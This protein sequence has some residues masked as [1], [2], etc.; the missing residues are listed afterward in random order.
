MNI[1]INAN[2][3]GGLAL[4]KWKSV[5]NI[6]QH[7]GISYQVHLTNSL[8]EL[9]IILRKIIPSPMSEKL[10]LVS[11]GGDGAINALI[12]ESFN[13][14]SEEERSFLHF[15]AINLGSSNDFH[16]PMELTQNFS[17]KISPDSL[18]QDLG[19]CEMSTINSHSKRFFVINSGIGLT[20][21]GN[22]FF[23]TNPIV[24]KLKPVSFALANLYTLFNII[25][26]PFLQHFDISLID[27]KNIKLT[28]SQFFSNIGVLKNTHVSGSMKFDTLVTKDNGLLDFVTTP[29]IN[30]LPLIR[31]LS[32]L[33][34]GKFLNNKDVLYHQ[35]KEVQITSET[36]FALELDGEV[37]PNIVS[38]R[39]SVQPKQ[40]NICKNLK[41]LHRVEI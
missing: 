31:L 38:A 12:N 27:D 13:L 19:L 40:L 10:Y 4:K 6:L 26:K 25:T 29:A 8:E 24:K 7:R 21:S 36:P 41:P 33:H 34:L 15:G 1:F 18:K 35:A 14:C 17:M 30:T 9:R 22:H 37:F 2:S 28:Y 5:E 39:Y 32:N 16:K 3:S 11:A 20:A 23:N